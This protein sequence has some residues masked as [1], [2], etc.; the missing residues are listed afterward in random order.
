MSKTVNSNGVETPDLNAILA[1]LVELK[2][3]FAGVK[4]RLADAEA[5]VLARPGQADNQPT[6]IPDTSAG[7]AAD[8]RDR[9]RELIDDPAPHRSDTDWTE[10]MDLAEELRPLKKQLPK[11]TFVKV[12]TRAKESR[13]LLKKLPGHGAALVQLR[14]VVTLLESVAD[15]GTEAG[16]VVANR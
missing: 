14:G 12:M 16:G 13:E 8:L 5:R 11:G 6:F 15:D 10:V 1:Q 9:L 7:L 3:D 4:A 2:A